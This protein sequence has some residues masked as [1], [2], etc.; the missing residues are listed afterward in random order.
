MKVLF[1]DSFYWIAL[2]DPS[3]QW[4]Q[5]VKNFNRNLKSVQFVTTDEVL[6]EF[7]NFFSGYNSTMRLGAIRRVRDMLQGHNVQVVPQNRERFITGLD[8][9]EQRPDK[10]YSLTDCISMQVM[11][12]MG[13]TEVLT[14]D[15][16]FA[17]EGFIILFL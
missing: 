3:D 13:I 2:L 1:A 11:K 16:H 14:H 6:S 5:R 17:Q 9:Y 10:E 7:L 12:A 8:L 15:R 4:H